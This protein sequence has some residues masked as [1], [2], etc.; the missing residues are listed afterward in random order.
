[1]LPDGTPARQRGFQFNP[2]RPGGVRTERCTFQIIARTEDG[3]EYAEDFE[4]DVDPTARDPVSVI[5]G[6]TRPT[7]G[8]ARPYT[9]MY[10]ERGTID[11]EGV[12]SV[13][14]WAVSLGATLVVQ[15][16]ADD[17]RFS[18]AKIGG[19]REDV[20]SVFP[21]YPKARLSG[22]SLT[23]QLDEADRDANRIL[24]QIECPNGFGH[25]KPF[26]SNK[27]SGEALHA[28]NPPPNPQSCRCRSPDRRQRNCR[29]RRSECT[30][31]SPN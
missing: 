14:G 29:P 11:S 6:P 2:P 12:L 1:M 18:E 28:H 17:E 31:T 23:M 9:V 4:I 22:F 7:V 8:A 24:A 21:A 25:R 16:F 5:A 27:C 30:V 10:I 26:P 3:F 19:E 15:I 20:A 13:V